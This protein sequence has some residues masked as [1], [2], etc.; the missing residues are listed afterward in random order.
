MLLFWLILL[1]CLRY[2]SQRQMSCNFPDHSFKYNSSSHMFYKRANYPTY[3][4]CHVI[5][6]RTRA[7]WQKG[8]LLFYFYPDTCTLWVWPAKHA[9]CTELYAVHYKLHIGRCQLASYNIDLHASL[10]YINL[11]KN[12]K[13]FFFF[14]QLTKI[15]SY[16]IHITSLSSYH[17]K[18]QPFWKEIS[19]AD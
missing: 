19:Y 15:H 4:Y 10:L 12:Q 17:Q 6:H 16:P 1:W 13:H 8:C 9:S 3:K 14:L 11:P 7:C 2:S 18:T 5:Q